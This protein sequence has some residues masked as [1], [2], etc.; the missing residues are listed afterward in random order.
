M[1]PV[2][3]PLSGEG[4][5]AM[6]RGG[7]LRAFL[8]KAGAVAVKDIRAEIRAREVAS[9]ML[10]FGLL[11]ALIFGLAFDLRVPRAEMVVPGIL[12]VIL[13]FA[14][15]LGLHRAFGAEADRGTLPGLLLAPVERSAIYLGKVGANLLYVLLLEL[16]LLPLML[17]LFDVNLFRPLILGALLLGSIGYVGVGTLFAALTTS[18]SARETLLPLLLLPVMAPVFLAGVSLTAGVLDGLPMSGLIRWLLILAGFDLIT[19]FLSFILFDF[20]WENGR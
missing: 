17:V 19:L 13:L 16:L 15:V 20:I 7:G 11:A 3:P 2:F 1:T 14:G 4:A 18:S 8:R 12:W 5:I 10:L 9:S 6:G